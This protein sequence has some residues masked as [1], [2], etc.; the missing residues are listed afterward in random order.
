MTKRAFWLSLG[1]GMMA[2]HVFTT[3]MFMCTG[4][5]PWALAVMLPITGGVFA[6]A[7]LRWKR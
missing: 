4:V 3:F 5:V 1:T 6:M 7:A 2:S